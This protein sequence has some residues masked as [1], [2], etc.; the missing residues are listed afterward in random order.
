MLNSKQTWIYDL[1]LIASIL[2]IFYAVWI[3]SH[4]LFTPDEG[5]YSEVARE[6]LVTHDFITPR[7]DGVPFL[8]KPIL[9][10]W[11]QV[12]AI[13][14]FGLKEWSLRLW[15]ATLGVLGCAM[16]YVTARVICNRRTAILATVILA[17]SPLYYGAAHFSNLD[18]EVASFISNAL[19][20]FLA[21]IH[22]P[23]GKQRRLFLYAA[24]FFSGC[25][26]LTKG[27]I[28][29]VFPVAI[30]GLWILILRRGD[31]LKKIHLGVGITIFL[32][33]ILPWYFLVQQANPKFL[34]YFF[35]TQ[36]ISRFLTNGDFNNKQAIWFYLP[37]IFI[38]SFPWSIFILQTFCRGIKQLSSPIE[39]FLL[40]WFFTILIFFSIPHSKT[41]GYILS[42][43]PCLAFLISRYLDAIWDS[44]KWLK[45]SVI[46][47]IICYLVG[48]LFIFTPHL[49][50]LNARLL[51]GASPY[52]LKIAIIL[53]ISGSLAII[54]SAKKQFS[55]LFVNL[56][57]TS[58]FL[59]LTLSASLV[60]FDIRS[61]KPLA[62]TL[63]TYLQPN[64]EVVA[65]YKYFQDLPIY[66]ER[67]IVIVNNWHSPT[68]PE[69]DNWVR[70]LWYG[71]QFQDTRNWLI[72]DKEFWRRWNSQTRLF[73]LGNIVDYHFL[74][75]KTN[76][77][78]KL[79][80][81]NTIA[82]FTNY[83]PKQLRPL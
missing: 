32:C 3:G 10:Y 8:D 5:R 29:I 17:T 21:G 61:I 22:L 63:K 73:V 33:V 76:H 70:E 42:L 71:M 40:C 45:S 16:L 24:Y 56:F 30:I 34:H 69:N 51:P 66:L 23:L 47:G 25:A 48:I 64:D 31:L 44:P 18:L 26:V 58:V 20:C 77:I 59:L 15:P 19:L 39:L 79:G 12:L 41:V 74:A 65:Y 36:Q 81:V 43:Y 2:G 72:D 75:L 28:G 6:M 80:Q 50:L 60:L 82:L 38:G 83:K 13:A 14:L 54:L 68:I 4:A 52:L 37:I 67:Q 35:V 57:I 11:L 7:V 62:L 1:L 49:S 55:L 9:Y 46:Y 27:L 53:C 78:Y